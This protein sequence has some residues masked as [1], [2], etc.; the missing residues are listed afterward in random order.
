MILIY[1]HIVPKGYSSITL[2]PFVFLKSAD[3][4]QKETLLNHEKIHLRQQLELL[5]IPFFFIYII[6]F[7]IRF[8]QYKN[9]DLAYRNI[10]FEQEAYCNEHDNSYLKHRTFWRFLKYLRSNAK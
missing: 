4:K 9:W 2:F 8:I 7:S 6:E 5:V 3:L 1:K 10:S